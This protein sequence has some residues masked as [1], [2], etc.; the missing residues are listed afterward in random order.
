LAFGAAL[1]LLLRVGDG[2][3]EEQPLGV[4]VLRPG[5]DLFAV[6][7]FDAAE[8]HAR[9]PGEAAIVDEYGQIVYLCLG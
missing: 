3:G 7:P 5:G 6:A 8:M 9:C 1:C 2:G 4:G